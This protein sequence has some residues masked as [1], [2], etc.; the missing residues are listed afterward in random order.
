MR[1]SAVFFDR[2]EAGRRIAGRLEEW[3]IQDPVVYAIPGGGV[4]VGGEVARLFDAPFDVVVVETLRAPGDAGLAIG[5]LVDGEEPERL[6]DP[7]VVRALGVADA[8]LRQETARGLAS[9]RRTARRLRGQ[10]PGVPVRDRTVFLADDGSASGTI[11]RAAARGLRQERAR[12]VVA[13]LPVVATSTLSAIRP[14]VDMVVWLETAADPQA[15]AF[16]YED[17][18][19]VPE[20]EMRRLLGVELA[21]R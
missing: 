9:V 14:E 18:S 4:A 16:V 13:V 10:R 20:E 21:V 11:L 3:R 1:V 5:S 8:Y 15:V 2:V 19:P 7:E 12:E 17:F 6:L